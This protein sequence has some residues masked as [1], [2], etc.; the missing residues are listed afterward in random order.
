[1][2]IHVI[3]GVAASSPQSDLV[4]WAAAVDAVA[5]FVQPRDL[6]TRVAGGATEELHVSPHHLQPLRR[7]HVDLRWL[8]H[9]NQV[10]IQPR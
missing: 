10:T 9:C 6:W 5:I 4:L 7:P 1:M 2:R 3:A 8:R